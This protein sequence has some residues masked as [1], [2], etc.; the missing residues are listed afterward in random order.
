[1]SFEVLEVSL[2][3]FKA[4][5]YHHY[6]K[7]AVQLLLNDLYILSPRH[8]QQLRWSYFIN[9]HSWV[10]CNIIPDDLH[11]EHNIQCIKL[12]CIIWVQYHVPYTRYIWW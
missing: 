7:K 5:Q 12:Y 8:S 11:M 3:I 1:M 6:C 10:G 2:V 4:S 9:T